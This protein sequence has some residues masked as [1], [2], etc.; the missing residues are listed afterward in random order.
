MKTESAIM[1]VILLGAALSVG[2]TL[3]YPLAA[4]RGSQHNK[5]KVESIIGGEQ[6]AWREV[7]G[8]AIP[9]LGT[10]SASVWKGRDAAGHE[11]E[12]P[13]CSCFESVNYLTTGS[14]TQN[15]YRSWPVEVLENLQASSTWDN[16]E[17]SLRV[18]DV[19]EF[20]ARVKS[21]TGPD[22]IGEFH[23]HI[24]VAEGGL[25]AGANNEPR[26]RLINGIPSE[27]NVWDVCTSRQ[28][29]LAARA[30]D[31]NW[32]ASGRD[33]TYQIKVYRRPAGTASVK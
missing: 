20:V 4:V 2:V 18:G 22:R 8:R 33:H 21:K 12:V 26:F 28:Y 10:T 5:S 9:P 31:Q 11:L 16:L 3:L 6:Q 13:A 19:V 29:Y 23:A 1:K 30:M 15:V 14:A 32:A 24:C 7:D 27:T 17:H 25:M